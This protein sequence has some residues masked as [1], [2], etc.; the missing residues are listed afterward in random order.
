MAQILIDDTIQ[1]EWDLSPSLDTATVVD[2]HYQTTCCIVG[3]GPAGAFLALLL[4]RQGIAVTLLEAH[5]NFER[6]FRGD[7]VHPATLEALA[8]LGLADRLLQLPHTKAYY[9]QFH[10]DQGLIT[11]DDFRHLKT[12][13]PYIMKLPQERFLEFLIA[14]ARQ[15]ANFQLVMGARVEQLLEE[16]GNVCGVRYRHAGNMVDLRAELTVG[17]DGRFSKTRQLSGLTPIKL[18]PPLDFLWFHLPRL[19]SDPH[20]EAVELYFGRGLFMVLLDRGEKWQIGCAIGKGT[21]QQVREAGIESLQQAIASCVPWFADRV[22]HLRNWQ[23][24]SLLSIESSRLERWYRPGLLL[25]GDAAHVMSPIGSVGINLAIQDA[26]AVANRVSEP[27]KQHQLRVADLAAIQQHREWRTRL[28]Q[29]WVSFIQRQIMHALNNSE[30]FQLPPVAQRVL[31]IP[32]VRSLPARITALGGWP[33][34]IRRAMRADKA[35]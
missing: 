19:E 29:G 23:Q 11:F 21:Y 12:P 5:K 7:T 4:A 1:H 8:E 34:H 22:H 2:D 6:E 30:P 32:F 28:T 24:I 14:E 25:I 33:E 9:V 10:T 31:G 15:Y 16:H 13:Y 26:V 27:L 18:S 17:A 35:S 20:A 3:G